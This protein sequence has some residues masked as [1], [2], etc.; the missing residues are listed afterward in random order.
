MAE[1][2]IRLF[3][4]FMPVRLWRCIATESNRY[5]HQHLNERVD[6][7]YAAQQA[8]GDETTRDAVLLK[9]T[10]QHKKIEPHEILH[11]IG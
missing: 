10:K 5:Y 11:C 7:M 6:R 9:E 4:Y 1:S 2:P 8:R 3:F